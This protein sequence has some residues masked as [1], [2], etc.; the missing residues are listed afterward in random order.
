[1]IK[2]KKGNINLYDTV[3]CGQIFRF[4]VFEDG[5]IVILNDRVV[6]FSEDDK[7]IY[8]CSNNEDN[9]EEVVSKFLDLNTDYDKINKFLLKNDC[10]LKNIIEECSGFKI[11]NSPKFETIVS[12]MISANNNVRNIK[13]SVDLMSKRYGKKVVFDDKEYYL[14]PNL[15]DLK[16]LN[17]DDYKNLKLGFRS[18]NIYNFIQKI[19]N[20]DINNIDIMNT[21]EALDYLMSF[22]G[23]GLKIAS[24][25]L[26]FGYKRFD[27]FPID[28]W[29]KKY[30]FDNYNL[31]DMKK[32]EEFTRNNYKEY[33]GL[34]IQ[35]MFHTKRNK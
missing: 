33:S 6:K 8:V 12:Y 5:I 11:I 29:V 31:S 7:Y 24:C 22:K 15:S 18:E 21:K 9:L 3:T 28:T 35:Y 30:M 26:L 32:I 27:V 20:D 1:M 10:S 2:I 25:I 13:K 23:I 19:N 4:E 16:K 14:F 34:V 17:I